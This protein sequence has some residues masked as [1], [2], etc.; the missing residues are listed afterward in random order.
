MAKRT[1]RA[2][3]DMCLMPIEEVWRY[4][5]VTI[6]S[7]RR[8]PVSALV[9]AGTEVPAFNRLSM[10]MNAGDGGRAAN[11]ARCRGYGPVTQDEGV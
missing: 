4:P 1:M 11:Y 10:F 9:P 3:G 8:P 7:F 2:F 6:P 5:L